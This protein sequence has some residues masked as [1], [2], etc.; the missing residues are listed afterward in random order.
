MQ[1][2]TKP[3]V[4]SDLGVDDESFDSYLQNDLEIGRHVHELEKA[5]EQIAKV[6]Q[7]AQE[8]GEDVIADAL[9]P[10][11]F[12][13]EDAYI[14]PENTQHYVGDR[15]VH[16]DY[17][18]SQRLLQGVDMPGYWICC[19]ES[20]TFL[21]DERACSIYG[22][23]HR[24]PY[25]EDVVIG[26]M[27][28]SNARRY[29]RVML[30]RDMGDVIFED[31]YVT[32]GPNKGKSYVVYGSVLSRFDDGRVKY[33]AGFISSV[34]SAFAEIISAEMTGDGF[35]TWDAVSNRLH[36]SN[37]YF[38]LLGYKEDEYPHTIDDWTNRIVHPDDREIIDVE[39]HILMSPK[40]GNSFEF[41]VRVLH[42]N[43]NYIWTI[44]RGIVT[45]RDPETGFAV[46]LIGALSDINLVQD[47]F[48]NI[49]Q[50]LYTDTLT[51]LKNRSYFQHQGNRWQE[52]EHQPV[53]V[54]YA[55]V[56]GLKITNDVLGH[57][58]GDV[59]ILAVSELIS[60]E[61]EQECDMMRL[62]GDEFLII[63]PHC[64][65]EESTNLLNRLNQAVIDHNSSPNSMPIF[66]GF[67][68][69]TM[70][71]IENDTL[72]AT[73]ERADVR[74]QAA[75]DAARIENYSKLKAYLEKKKGRPVSMRDGRR[76]EY[77]SEDERKKRSK[78]SY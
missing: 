67:G 75:K 35:Y 10:H 7:L 13:K 70:G 16:E 40:Y 64:S 57:A 41:C 12:F 33:C 44:G 29:M 42:K 32:S 31:V 49:K 30:S 53:S 63:L 19:G 59:L 9:E 72:H 20:R 38:K 46:G 27:A 50:L 18:A 39:R 78:S 28:L 55:D 24:T 71:E 48:E 51:G 23:P 21:L 62:A 26:C 56:T 65:I 15:K 77:L 8:K 36:F 58:D 76:L 25:P 4:T 60:N 5:R 2:S 37:S 45:K 54:I 73:I 68:R 34:E 22:L 1:D 47:N 52:A 6:H 66:C 61:I 3:T 14:A 11:T 17:E 74:M 43:G 69:A